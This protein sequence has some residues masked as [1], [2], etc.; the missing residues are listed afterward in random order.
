MRKAIVLAGGRGERLKSRIAH[1]P[2]P[3]AP[4]C[5][6]PFLE[7]VLDSIANLPLTEVTLSVGF[8]AGIIRN[9]FGLRYRNLN[10]RYSEETTPLGT[11]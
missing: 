5:R 3:M 6:R 8:R 9:H 10:L 4:V 11:G 1:L 7:Y 2:K